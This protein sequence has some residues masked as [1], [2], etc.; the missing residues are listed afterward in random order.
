MRRPACSSGSGDGFF[1]LYGSK[2]KASG[3]SATVNVASTLK[4]GTDL[5]V[6]AKQK[7]VNIIGSQ[8]NA[9]GDLGIDAA[10]DVNITPG[11]EQS[12]AFEQTR[13]SGI[14]ISFSSG[15][16]GFSIGLGYD[17]QTDGLRQSANTNAL[18]SLNAGGNLAISSG[19]DINLQATRARADHD[20]S[21]NAV[22]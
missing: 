13:R 11:A 9:G 8:L 20:L 14:G 1:S 5:S 6:A 17:K 15:N 4:A 10:Q 12:A 22:L 19:R 7:D 16:S 3:Q 21:L 2:E 18:S